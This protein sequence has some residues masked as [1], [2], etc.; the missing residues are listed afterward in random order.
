MVANADLAAEVEKEHRKIKDERARI[1]KEA[2]IER[3]TQK[4]DSVDTTNNDE[5]QDVNHNSNRF[6]K[7]SSGW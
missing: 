1:E 6:S 3:E 5:S 7:N 2:R 4:R